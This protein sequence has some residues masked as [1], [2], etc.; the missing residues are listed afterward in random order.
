MIQ[1]SGNAFSLNIGN[2]SA[3]YF[4]HDSRE[5]ANRRPKR[6]CNATDIRPIKG[7]YL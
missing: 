3:I 7:A 2:V 6:D 4:R 1:V 5:C